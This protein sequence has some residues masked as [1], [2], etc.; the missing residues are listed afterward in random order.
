MGGEVIFKKGM[1]IDLAFVIKRFKKVA[2]GTVVQLEGMEGKDRDWKRRG[3]VM[4]EQKQLKQPKN[5][6][7][8][9]CIK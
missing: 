5:L 4:I 3:H 2:L 6:A 9:K 8:N 7:G 1:M